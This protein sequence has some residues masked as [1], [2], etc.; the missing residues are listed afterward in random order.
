MQNAT[1]VC[2]PRQNSVREKKFL[3]E[4]KILG[5]CLGFPVHFFELSRTNRCLTFPNISTNYVLIP[6][7]EFLCIQNQYTT[8]KKST[9]QSE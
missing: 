8:C 1:A 3:S 2:N 6:D 7:P 9:L 4:K 5:F